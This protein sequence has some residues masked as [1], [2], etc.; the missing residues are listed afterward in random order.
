MNAAWQVYTERNV[1]IILLLGFSSGLPLALTGSTLSLWMADEGVDLGTIGLFSLVGLPYVLKFLW[2]P[3]VDAAPV[4]LFTR[5]LGRRRGWLVA[6]QLALALAIGAMGLVDPV[7]A[8][9]LMAL[10]AVIVAFLSATQ[11]IVIDAFRVETLD[12]TEYAAGM[13]NYVAAYRVALLVAGAGAVAALGLFEGLGAPSATLWSWAYGLMA[14][15][16]GVGLAASFFAAEPKDSEKVESQ[17]KALSWAER[18]NHA[19]VSPFVDF[20]KKPGWLLILSFVLLFKFGDAFAGAMVTPFAIGIGFEKTIYAYV[21]NGVGLPA[22]LIGGFAGGFL[23][24]MI[25]MRNALWIG[26][27]LQMVSNLAFCW[28]AWI[29]PATEALAVTVG[30]EAFTGGMGTV[31]FVAYLSSLCAAREFTATQF[32]LLSALA[33]VGRTVLSASAGF[34]AAAIGWVPFFILTTLAAV[35]GLVLLAWLGHKKLLDGEN[36]LSGGRK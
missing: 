27:I 12:E 22:A 24:R 13:A 5:W 31:I 28:L 33:A 4:P 32:A 25:S 26:G 2:A 3:L 30:I 14:A 6:T 16:M 15:L 7:R 20:M 29:G 9:L 10:A 35:P 36:P 8:P 21:A 34:V 17:R 18:F 23:G 1:L 11:D 19:T